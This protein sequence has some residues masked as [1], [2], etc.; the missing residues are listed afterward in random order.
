[1][2]DLIWSLTTQVQ[3]D[4]SQF[5]V[6]Q[7]NNDKFC[8]VAN[9][10]FAAQKPIFLSCNHTLRLQIKVVSAIQNSTDALDMADV[11]DL[12]QR[13]PLIYCNLPYEGLLL[14]FYSFKVVT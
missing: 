3:A 6:T 1:M 8:R 2:I 14:S 11:F 12:F 5:N 13:I 10:T 7:I 4:I 9:E